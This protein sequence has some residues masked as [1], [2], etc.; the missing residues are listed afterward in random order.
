MCHGAYAL[1]GLIN[2]YRGHSQGGRGLF[3]VMVQR[4]PSLK[5]SWN[6]VEPPLNIDSDRGNFKLLGLIYWLYLRNFEL[7]GGRVVE[8]ES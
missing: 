7:F 8:E 3:Q 2:V 6:L 5:I 4:V 1:Q